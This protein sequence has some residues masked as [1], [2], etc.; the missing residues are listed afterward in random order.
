M[1]AG[2]AQ[3]GGLYLQ[4]YATT[5]MGTAGAGRH[6]YASDG[7][8]IIH[9][10]AGMTRLEGHVLFGG[11]APG[12]STVKFDKTDSAVNRGG[13]GGEQGGF[14][15]L[16]GGG[17]SHKLHDR[18]RLG[19]GVLSVSGAA[20]DPENEWAGRGQVTKLSLFT[21]A[22][23]PGVAVKVTDWLSV[24][25]NGL[26]VYAALDWRLRTPADQQLR[27]KDADDVAY[28]GMASIL[29][30][31]MEGLRIGV[32]YQSE[33]DLKLRGKAKGP[34]GL[35]PAFNLELPLAQYVRGS[36]YWDA[37]DKLALL[38]S[39][40]W[41]DWSTLS[42]TGVTL[43]GAPSQSVTLG[44][45]DTWRVGAG[46]HYQLTPEWMLQTG[47]SY[48]SSALKNKN[49]IAALPIDEQHRVGFGAIH[50]LSES[51]RVGVTFEWLHLGAAKIRQ[52]ALRGSYERNDIFFVGLN[53]N[54][55]VKSW[56]ETFGFDQ[57]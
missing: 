29:L 47:Y 41:E 4:E 36:V 15:P 27:F 55:G 21:L 3:A 30:E 26:I 12:G 8:T 54:W 24:A 37:T 44:F 16:L 31:P 10:P 25:G 22:A 19:M 56:R 53:V 39:A 46:I 50:Q 6:A 20:L 40:G 9:N 7:G 38:L 43:G 52:P 49:R 34:A 57:S 1:I 13:N 2:T 51:V 23:N 11:F 45:D 17:Y 35:N 18:V 28:A 5:S 33:V 14:I 48:D 42:T 32:V